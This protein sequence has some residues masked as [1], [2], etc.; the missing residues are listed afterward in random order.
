MLQISKLS[1]KAHASY[2]N[3]KKV[4]RKEEW[5]KRKCKEKFE[6]AYL[7]NGLAD[8]AQIWNWRC[9]TLRK[10]SQKHMY[11]SVKGVLSSQH[12]DNGVSI[13]KINAHRFLS[14]LFYVAVHT[15][16]HCANVTL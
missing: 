2:S 4:F 6:G 5:Y 16:T 9:P 10:V 11:V 12:A 7:G 8:S 3:S 14:I 15:T 13:E 1:I